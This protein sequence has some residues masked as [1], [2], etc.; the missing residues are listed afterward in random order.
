MCGAGVNMS[1]GSR[2][3]PSPPFHRQVL[4]LGSGSVLSKVPMA[5]WS[6]CGADGSC[7]GHVAAGEGTEASNDE[8]EEGYG[9][10]PSPLKLCDPLYNPFN[11]DGTVVIYST[12]AL[13]Q[14]MH[15]GP[16]DM[17]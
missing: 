12:N 10:C 1:R 2:D 5:G 8:G 3:C 15:V 17:N 11:F 6:R 14:S 4:C 16:R 13:I 9:L 7:V